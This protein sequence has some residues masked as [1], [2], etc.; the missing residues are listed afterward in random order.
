MIDLA[1]FT[2]LLFTPAGRLDRRSYAIALC[3]LVA[4]SFVLLLNFAGFGPIFALVGFYAA[5]CLASKR[6]HDANLSGALV[7]I[8]V[9]I[10]GLYL[11]VVFWYSF[12]AFGQG[13]CSGGSE[14]DRAMCRYVR[15][16]SA[17]PG[18]VTGG[19]FLLAGFIPGTSG[20]NRYGQ[21]RQSDPSR[22]EAA[23]FCVRCGRAIG[24]TD[25]F[26]ANCGVRAN[27]EVNS[28]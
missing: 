4:G 17:I 28:N 15:N 5:L 22:T 11:L 27:V 9:L 23:A 13:T 2:T 3:A 12:L 21:S 10:I 8:P 1:N 6:L 26:C 19:F 25:V 16:H 24:V 14:A 7:L 18:W 20:V